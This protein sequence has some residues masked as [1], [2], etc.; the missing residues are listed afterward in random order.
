[1]KYE[2]PKLTCPRCYIEPLGIWV[3]IYEYEPE[4]YFACVR[5]NEKDIDIAKTITFTSLYDDLEAIK[6]DFIAAY[7]EA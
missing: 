4:N 7:K 5:R 3:T 6:E 2:I 1:M